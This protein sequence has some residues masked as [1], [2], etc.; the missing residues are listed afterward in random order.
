M[1]IHFN[2]DSSILLFIHDFCSVYLK[3]EYCNRNITFIVK[4][5]KLLA[6]SKANILHNL[7]ISLK[8]SGRDPKGSMEPWLEN[9]NHLEVIQS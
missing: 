1:V 8:S 7:R 6:G 2:Y 9:T 3:S 5:S 4:C